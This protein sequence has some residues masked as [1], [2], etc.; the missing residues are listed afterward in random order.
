MVAFRYVLFAAVVFLLVTLLAAKDAEAHN[1]YPD[2]GCGPGLSS[3][4]YFWADGPASGWGTVAN[5]W[6]GCSM[7]TLTQQQTYPAIQYAE[8]YL[9]ISSSYNHTYN[10]QA[11]V[12]DMGASCSSLSQGAHYHR[13]ANGTAGGINSHHSFNQSTNCSGFCYTF[14]QGALNGSN[15]GKVDVW[16]WTFDGGVTRF[17]MVDVFCF[18][19]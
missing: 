9:P 11:Y 14:T 5:G 12:P 10:L 4:G 8:W 3:D 2:D 15:G 6:N 17:L 16:D 1:W 19:Q 18:R 7:W 13:Y